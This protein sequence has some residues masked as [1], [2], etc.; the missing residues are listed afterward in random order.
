VLSVI[1]LLLL[2][3]VVVVV[4]VVA[5]VIILVEVGAVYFHSLKNHCHRFR[6]CDP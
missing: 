2:L 5:A 4:V 6:L 3:L 1:L